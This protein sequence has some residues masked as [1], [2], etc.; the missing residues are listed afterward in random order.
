MKD[1]V[2]WP[3]KSP[4]RTLFTSARTGKA[5]AKGAALMAPPFPKDPRPLNWSLAG[6]YTSFSCGEESFFN[7]WTTPQPYPR[8]GEA[9]YSL[10]NLQEWD[11]WVYISDINLLPF[12]KLRISSKYL[13]TCEPYPVH[14]IQP[15]WV[16]TEPH[17]EPL[18]YHHCI[19][20]C[21]T[22]SRCNAD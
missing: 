15:G 4:T 2:L 20:G 1:I 12:K 13:S 8:P 10:A 14:Q 5:N 18:P 17:S 19:P 6:W 3:L 22:K 7:T 11:T 21:L 9:L 16:E